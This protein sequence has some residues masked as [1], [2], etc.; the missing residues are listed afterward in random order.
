MEKSERPVLE[1][2]ISLVLHMKDA[3]IKK[4]KEANTKLLN[5][6]KKLKS[7]LN[8]AKEILYQVKK[9]YLSIEYNSLDINN[10]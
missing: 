5:E 9:A 4:L 10:E 7:S 6:N 1:Q 3:E 2:A 8:E